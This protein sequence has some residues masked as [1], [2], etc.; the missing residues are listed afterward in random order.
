MVS[1]IIPL[2]GQKR[3]PD[4]I[5]PPGPEMK[6]QDNNSLDLNMGH[7]LLKPISFNQIT[8]AK[9]RGPAVVWGNN[10]K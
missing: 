9:L 1:F 10:A 6:T 3:S 7:T 4:L 5:A 2:S 8:K